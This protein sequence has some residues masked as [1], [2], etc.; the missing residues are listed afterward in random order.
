MDANQIDQSSTISFSRF[1]PYNAV[2]EHIRAQLRIVAGSLRGRKLDCVVH[3]D[4]RPTPQM[5]REALFSILGNAVPERPFYDIF[6]GT[7]ANGLEAISRGASEAVFLERD[8]RLA[9]DIDKHLRKFEVAERC[10]VLKTDVYR[11]AERWIPPTQPL[12]IFLSPPF[13]DLEERRDGFLEMV[14]LLMQKV[15]ADSTVTIQ[16]ETG[17]PEDKLPEAA[18]WDVRKYGRNMLFIWVKPLGPGADPT[19]NHFP[20]S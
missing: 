13:A 7:G 18:N 3:E 1:A 2:M 20:T 12:N 11:W 9:A 6:A 15:P 4:L 8:P 14:S 19:A 17:F 5:V 10:R 16:G